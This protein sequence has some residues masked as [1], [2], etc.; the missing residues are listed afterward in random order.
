MLG[1]YAKPWAELVCGGNQSVNIIILVKR[2]SVLHSVIYRAAEPVAVNHPKPDTFMNEH[3]LF[4]ELS[5]G[6]PI[7]ARSGLFHGAI[8]RRLR[9]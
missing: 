2:I 1:A 3:A 4:S 6:E 7:A 5:T 9:R 8:H